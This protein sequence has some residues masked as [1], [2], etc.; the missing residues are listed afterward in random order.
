MFDPQEEIDNDISASIDFSPSTP[1]S[2][3]PILTFPITQQ[4]Q[5]DFTSMQP[6]I[7]LVDSVLEGFSQHHA[8]SIG[9]IMTTTPITSSIFEDDCLSSVPAATY[10]HLNASSPF[11]APAIGTF[12]PTTPGAFSSDSSVI[13]ANSIFNMA[14]ELQSQDLEYQG[15]NGG[16]YC[17]DSMQR[18]FNPELQVL[19]FF[20]CYFLSIKQKGYHNCSLTMC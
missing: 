16:I 1:F 14:N 5:F 12:L 4:D 9:P 10:M 13:L 18:V 11:L 6:Q 17:I 19:K 15:E 3:P 7:S 2:D 20:N 8:D